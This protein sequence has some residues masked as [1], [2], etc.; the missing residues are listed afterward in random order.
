MKLTAKNI[1]IISL[2]VGLICL[3]MMYVLYCKFIQVIEVNSQ[4]INYI[5][6]HL[7]AAK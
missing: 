7:D 3:V 2:M 5:C 1:S 4:L 6:V